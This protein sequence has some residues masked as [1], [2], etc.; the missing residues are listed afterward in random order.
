MRPDFNLMDAF[1]YIDYEGLGRVN[2]I[3]FEDFLREIGV[4]TTLNDIFLFMR[5]YDSDND[6]KLK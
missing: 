4:I 5:K 6:G 2:S 1:R 3:L